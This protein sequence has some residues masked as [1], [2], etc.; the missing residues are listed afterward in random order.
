MFPLA[1]ETIFQQQERTLMSIESSLT[2]I[3]IMLFF[4]GLLLLIMMQISNS[5]LGKIL[6]NLRVM[7]GLL[8]KIAERSDASRGPSTS[9]GMTE[10]REPPPVP[11]PDVYKL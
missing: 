11:Q 9:L 7:N 1:A 4:G 2:F 10:G 5:K 3:G 6:N 8:Q